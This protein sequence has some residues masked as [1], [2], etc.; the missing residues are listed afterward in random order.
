[1]T[2]TNT[3]LHPSPVLMATRILKETETIASFGIFDAVEI[4]G[5]ATSDMSGR[6]NLDDRRSIVRL[7]SR[8]ER[9]SSGRAGRLLSMVFW[10]LNVLFHYGFRT[11]P[12]CINVHTLTTLPLGVALKFLTG[13]KLIYDP[14]ELETEVLSSSKI[15]KMLT[16]RLERAMIYRCDA[17]FVVGN[18]IADFYADLYDIDRPVV[19]RN[20]PSADHDT[21]SPMDL[22]SQVGLGPDDILYLY[23]GLLSAG[24]GIEVTVEAFK[25][26]SQSKPNAHI[27]FLGFGEL[28]GFVREAAD[29]HPT[30]HLFDPVP[31]E[32]VIDAAR[33]ADVGW[34]LIEDL[35]LS[36]YYCSPNKLFQSLS[37]GIPVVASDFPE[38]AQ[39]IEESG[40]GWLAAPDTASI[41][42]AVS[43]IQ[44]DEVGKMAKAAAA[45]SVK[46]N[47]E[48][49]CVPRLGAA[50]HA[51][52]A[53][54][55]AQ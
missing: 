32:K 17:V 41:V 12:A 47:W 2:K 43:A 10:M 46:Y 48:T 19:I 33:S 22:K 54:E 31:S 8:L 50:Y 53:N 18:K 34:S 5:M 27:G 15:R 51:L 1:M 35:C 39:V 30:I 52:F 49:E 25:E 7:R 20:L 36:Y 40:A 45:W 28:E 4:V 42:K 55:A 37:A 24:R 3:H 14:H 38:M 29:N 44:A 6:E 11:K 13:S 23:I 21:G 16:R 26:L 9:F